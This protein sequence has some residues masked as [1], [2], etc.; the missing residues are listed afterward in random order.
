M[1]SEQAKQLEGACWTNTRVA[2]TLDFTPICLNVMGVQRRWQNTTLANLL[3]DPGCSGAQLLPYVFFHREGSTR[4]TSRRSVHRT[5]RVSW[6]RDDHASRASGTRRTICGR[7]Q[8]PMYVRE[9]CDVRIIECDR[10]ACN[11]VNSGLHTKPSCSVTEY[12]AILHRC[13]LT[14]AR[15]RDM[16]KCTWTRCLAIEPEIMWTEA[17]TYRH[18]FRNQPEHVCTMPNIHENH[19]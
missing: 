3:S 6:V 2:W 17:C 13:P 11:G 19:P 1:E 7:M 15:T 18:F 12:L 16:C 5:A 10:Y 14:K 4:G 8:Q 9:K